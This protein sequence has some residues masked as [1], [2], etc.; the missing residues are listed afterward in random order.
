VEV[1]ISPQWG[2]WTW[3]STSTTDLRICTA[4]DK[5]VVRH[6]SKAKMLLPVYSFA[7]QSRQ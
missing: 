4:I 6:E 1:M 7:L 5:N 3:I 2:H